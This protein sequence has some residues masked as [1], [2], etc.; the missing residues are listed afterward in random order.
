MRKIVEVA[1]QEGE[2]ADIEGFLDE[3]GEDVLVGREGPEQAGQ[4][5]VDHD[6]DA[7]EPM[8]IA[9]DEPKAGVDV[10]GEDPQEPIDDARAAH[11]SAAPSGSV[12]GDAAVRL[13][14]LMALGPDES[15]TA[16]AF[17]CRGK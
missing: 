17:R 9:V 6:Q 5:N 14:A 16:G 15:A 13:R 10:L 7:R 11:G 12:P 3:A 8:D 1:D 2:E 4:R